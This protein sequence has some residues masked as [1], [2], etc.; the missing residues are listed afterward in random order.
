[1]AIIGSDFFRDAIFDTTPDKTANTVVATSPEKL[2][3]IPSVN[4]FGSLRQSVPALKQ[5]LALR[6]SELCLAAGDSLQLDSR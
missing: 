5:E 2:T 4:Y 3:F 6:G 1:L